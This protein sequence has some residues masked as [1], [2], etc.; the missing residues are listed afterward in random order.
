[1]QRSLI[2]S[3]CMS[4][5]LHLIPSTSKCFK[6]CLSF[7]G[8][9]QIDTF[10]K[11]NNGPGVQH[12]GLL[13]HNIFSSV[14]EWAA[15]DVKFIKPP[16]HYY[17]EVYF[18]NF[19]KPFC[20]NQDFH[21]FIRKIIQPYL[22]IIILILISTGFSCKASLLPVSI[23]KRHRLEPSS[24]STLSRSTPSYH[25]FLGLL[26]RLHPNTFIS[27]TCCCISAIIYTPIKMRLKDL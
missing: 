11:E 18:A 27:F 12:V 1:M 13:S 25:L 24:M 26:L 20:W 23:S 15:K 4:C 21:I 9:N 17:N 2:T 5:H 7:K 16:K 10:L 19:Q 8:P 22:A 3:F 14:Q 6:N